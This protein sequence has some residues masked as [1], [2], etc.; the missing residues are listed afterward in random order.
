MKSFMALLLLT[1]LM[2]V[3]RAADSPTTSFHPAPGVSASISIQSD[4]LCWEITRDAIPARD[5]I[6]VRSEAVP[7]IDIQDFDFS[8][9]PGF[10]IW[11]MDEG[12]ATY[13]IYRIFTY[14]RI[15]NTF[16]E[17]TPN[18]SCGDEFINLRVDRHKRRLLSTFWNQ[19]TPELCITRL[20]RIK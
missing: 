1:T 5:C 3:S 2:P 20:R 19:N 12:K 7:H 8:G 13:S 16:I 4:D 6:K 17:R 11:Q 10:S 14:S 18:P 9:M 15:R